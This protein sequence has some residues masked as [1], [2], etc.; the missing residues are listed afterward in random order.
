MSNADLLS[1]NISKLEQIL[2]SYVNHI[3]LQTALSEDIREFDILC[4]ALDAI[5][6]AEEGISSYMEMDDPP[7]SGSRYIVLYGILQI[8]FVEQDAVSAISKIFSLNE[9]Q[10][11]EIK[12]IREIRN[13]NIGH[14]VP[15]LENK[16][17]CFISRSEMRLKRF[18]LMLCWPNK[19][20]EF[21]AVNVPNLIRRQQ[22][23]LST[24]LRAVIEKL[25][26]EEISHR[27]KFGKYK[28]S[29][30]L[31]PS[32]PWLLSKLGTARTPDD[33]KLALG[34]LNIMTCSPICP[35][36]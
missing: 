35:R 3:R 16:P 26:E 11:E 32:L 2:R 30:I 1:A 27:Q 25:R 7:D 6:D 21:R 29:D 22:H 28:L 34:H 10:S 36:L 31:H 13:Y 33:K 19:K 4:S 12:E 23:A 9:R 5:G 17:A 14:P 20:T 8:L 15:N 18:K 24:T